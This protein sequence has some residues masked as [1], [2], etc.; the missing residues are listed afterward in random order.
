MSNIL[1][2]ENSILRVVL[3]LRLSDEDR[4]KLSKE[5]LSESI[6]NQ[7]TLLRAYAEE[8]GWKVVGVYNDEDWS[9]SDATRPDFNK[10]IK[11]CQKGNVDIVLVKSQSR[12]AR[13]MELVERYVHNLFHEWNVRFVTY[14]EK[15]DNTRKE[16]KKT[17][18]LTAMTDQWYLEDTSINIRETFRAKRTN[19]ELTASFASY[20]VMKDP[21][22]KNHLL[23]DPIA[24]EVVKR[25][26]DEYMA[27]NGLEKIANNLNK[28]K[29]LSP[30]EY[31]L[32]NGSKLKIPL[33]KEYLDFGYIEK[34]GTYILNISF[35]NNED[36]ILKDL[37]SFNY[38]TTDMK[39]LNNKCDIVLK[40]YTETKTKIYYSEDENL[41]IN[42]FSLDDCILLKENDLLPKTAKVLI[43]YTK[44]LDRT[45]IIDYQFEVTLK[46]NRAQEEFLIN[47]IMNKANGILKSEFS[48]NLRKKFKWSSQTVKKILTDEV[49][50]GN[51]VQFKTTTVSYK[52]HTVIKNDDE[53]RI[54]KDNTHESI[55]SKNVFYTIQERLQEKSRSSQGGEVHAFSNKVYCMNCNKLFF[56]CGK[57]DEN[58]Y[59]YLCCKDKK[60]KWA[61][62]TNSKYLREEELHTFVLEQLNNLLVRFYDEDSLKEMHD[63]VI[64]QD[65]FKDKLNSLEQEL[66]SINKELQGKS[67][68]FQKLYEDR[69]NGIL[70]EKEF[71]ILLNKYKDDNS[72]LE[73][74][75]NIIKKE[76]TSTTAKKESLKSKKNIFKKYR[77]IDKLNVEIVGDFIDKV[78]IG[79]YNDETGSREIKILWNFA[80]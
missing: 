13:D 33:I 6:K 79:K 80:I 61:N 39:T 66:K 58:G 24:C 54:R 55:V 17:S 3:Y 75:A 57:K 65:L 7:E 4:N 70:P 30:Y 47:I 32:L 23:I 73:E 71:L 41:D 31:K 14:I 12:F 19:G 10:M 49:Y 45:H 76:I 11:E 2:A 18:Q 52:N 43:S 9:G 67:T 74:R 37:V 63:E 62:C 5:Q 16:T 36:H 64:E 8:N 40:K 46:E 1:K 34:T 29:I 28:D 78:L 26:F 35:T 15:I 22:N 53:D 50:I 69:T 77:H 21:E 38:I 72:K 20:G 27:G 56:K 42:N 48:H 59:C 25:I 68:Y 60:D 51:L 44:E